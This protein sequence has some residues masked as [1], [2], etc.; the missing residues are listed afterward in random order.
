MY[1]DAGVLRRFF[2]FQKDTFFQPITF[3][4]P[5]LSHLLIPSPLKSGKLNLGDLSG[6]P[7]EFT[8][9]HHHFLDLPTLDRL[10]HHSS[11][12]IQ[13][14]ESCAGCGAKIALTKAKFSFNN[15]NTWTSSNTRKLSS[16]TGKRGACYLSPPSSMRSN[17]SSNSTNLLR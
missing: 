4:P 14:L 9:H 11:S 15:R 1:P 8:S 17:A 6:I 7:I 10:I 13:M 16:W 2:G 12:A 3:G 5:Q